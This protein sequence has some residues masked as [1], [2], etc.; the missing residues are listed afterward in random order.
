[1]RFQHIIIRSSI[2]RKGGKTR[3]DNDV[4]LVGMVIPVRG[5]LGRSRSSAALE[6]ELMEVP[7]T[8]A[9]GGGLLWLWFEFPHHDCF[10]MFGCF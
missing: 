8:N 6:T 3:D 7:F 2:F 10:L 4:V 9:V 1:M 5:W